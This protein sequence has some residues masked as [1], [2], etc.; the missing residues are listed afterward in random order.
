M[1]TIEA[2]RRPLVSAP[3][4]SGHFRRSPALFATTI[5]MIAALFLCD[6]FA[7]GI[8]ISVFY[9]VALIVL[10]RAGYAD[11]LRP[12]TAALI[13]MVFAVHFLKSWLYA[14]GEALDYRLANRALIAVV[15][16][17]LNVLLECRAIGAWR[18]TDWESP[19]NFRQDEDEID[20]T[21]AICLGG[22]AML[23]II[24]ADILFPVNY[25]LAILYLAPL[26]LCV[27]IRS[28]TLLWVVAGA[29]LVLT[30]VGYV[31]GPAATPGLYLDTIWINRWL[32]GVTLV[33]TTV[34]L[35]FRLESAPVD[36]L[37]VLVST[38]WRRSNPAF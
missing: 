27:W 38:A 20:E 8:T 9:A 22:V 18:H 3:A 23:A 14:G 5:A 26:F 11:R 24:V 1:N 13:C 36:S 2:I 7:R 15:L 34:L 4:A 6:V 33:L 31:V 37:P 21:L 19:D 29:S 10:V 25:N 16:V 17:S 30:Y 35:H 32:T 12:A 28:R